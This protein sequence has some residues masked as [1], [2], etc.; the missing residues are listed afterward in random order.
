MTRCESSQPGSPGEPQIRA[1]RALPFPA[2]FLFLSPAPRSLLRHGEHPPFYKLRSVQAF[3]PPSHPSLGLL[4]FSQRIPPIKG[5]HEHTH[6]ASQHP[7]N[8][9]TSLLRRSEHAVITPCARRS[10]RALPHLPW[11]LAEPEHEV[12]L[13]KLSPIA[14]KS[15][16]I[17]LTHTELPA[18]PAPTAAPR[19]WGAELE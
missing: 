5:I 8:P 11:V 12:N 10:Q 3:L 19:Y 2:A 6:Q 17:K 14:G 18:S 16:S 9:Q 15:L 13:A 7:A 1:A 4:L